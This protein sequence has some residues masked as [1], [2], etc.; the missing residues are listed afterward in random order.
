MKKFLIL[1]L[2]VFVFGQFSGSIHPYGQ[3]RLSDNSQLNLPFRFAEFELNL[4][5][6]DFGE[7]EFKSNI[8]VEYRWETNEHQFDLREAYL[9]W[10][11]TFGEVK[12][13]KQIH[14]WGAVDGNNPT[15]N[16]NA[17][18][19]YYMFLPGAERKL[20]SI[21]SSVKA[22][23]GDLQ[24]EGVIIPE[25]TPNRMPFGEED[26]PFDMQKPPIIEEVENPIE[27]G[28]RLQTSAFESDFSISYFNGFDR[29]F[30][31]KYFN[32]P[33][34]E[35]GFRNTE[36]FGFDFVTFINEFTF[37][38]EFAYFISKYDD[39]DIEITLVTLEEHAEYLQYVLQAE[40]S[41]PLDI[42]INSQ[43]IGSKTFYTNGMTFDTNQGLIV[44][45]TPD[46]FKHGMGTPFAMFSEQS[47]LVSATG[48]IFDNRLEL[49]GSSMFNLTEKG[50]MF[51]GRVDY[52]PIENW[53]IELG[54]TQFIGEENDENNSFTKLEDFSQIN[55]GLKYSF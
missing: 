50:L 45:L 26:F 42:M 49:V 18:D 34:L 14:S 48:N 52:S 33:S 10:Y 27:Y 5:L 24:I 6:N 36:Q 7:W 25:H 32:A 19:Y 20:G 44:E 55:I 51:G 3:F 38:G 13:G 22:Y 1:L 29:G 37:R 30:S 9:M 47:L 54:I 17:Y 41:G 43:F 53:K 39:S 28:V 31:Q 2:P 16:L 46:N 11:P 4:P 40:W 23:F 21:S 12:L 15:D 8:A 35:I